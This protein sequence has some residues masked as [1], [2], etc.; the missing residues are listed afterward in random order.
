ISKALQR[1]SDAI[2]NAIICYNTQAA[3]LV[4]PRPKLTWKDI[5]EYSFLGEFD[6]LLTIYRVFCC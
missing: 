3:L 6:L 2:Q 1:C 5:V 4:P